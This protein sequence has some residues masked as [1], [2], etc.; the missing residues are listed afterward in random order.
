MPTIDHLAVVLSRRRLIGAG[1]AT[2]LAALLG[3]DAEARP[4]RKRRAPTETV[5]SLDVAT[6]PPTETAAPTATSTE[7]PTDAPTDTPVPTDVPPPTETVVPTATAT[8]T[9]APTATHTATATATPAPVPVGRVLVARYE[10]RPTF[11]ANHLRYRPRQVADGMTFADPTWGPTRF[12]DVAT[13]AGWDFLNTDNDG[14]ERI[15]GNGDWFAVT[16]N[17]PARVAVVWRGG[18]SVASCFAAWT[19]GPDIRATQAGDAKTWP[20]FWRDVPAGDLVLCGVNA[21]LDGQVRN[22]YLL[23][24]AEEGGH[25]SG[26]PL[27]GVAPNETCPDW[28]HDRW[29]GGWH[30]QI[31]PVAWCYYRHE[32]GTDPSYFG[33]DWPVFGVAAIAAGMP[34]AHAGFKVYVVDAGDGFV[35]RFV[36]HFGTASLARACVAHHETQIAVRDAGGTLLADLRFLGNFGTAVNTNTGVPLSP[37]ACPDQATTATGTGERRIPVATDGGTLYEPWRFDQRGNAL[38]LHGAFVVNSGEGIVVCDTNQCATPVA[39]GFSG[40]HRFLIPTTD[41]GRVLLWL[42][43]AGHGGDGRFCTDPM[44]MEVRDCDATDAVAQYVAPGLD[45]TYGCGDHAADMRG[46]GRPFVCGTSDGDAEREDSI[47]AA[48]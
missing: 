10:H 5:A 1:V 34:E 41:G 35:W 30:P 45:L 44:G 39:T 31:D 16:L 33:G 17:R 46:W 28:L 13:Y 19:P 15:R 6:E 27:P 8:E 9:A 14:S 7:A 43:D 25:P 21:G 4:R 20:T 22:T 23:F 3:G 24:L 47:G 26:D 48:N 36:H 29:G 37:A 38:G 42:T 2:A 40:T 32:H 11:A 18:P 12:T